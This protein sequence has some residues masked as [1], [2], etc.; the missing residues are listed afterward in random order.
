[1]SQ[2]NIYFILLLRR[3]RATLRLNKLLPP[4]NEWWPKI[5]CERT[6]KTNVIDSQ[7]YTWKRNFPQKDSKWQEQTIRMASNSVHLDTGHLGKN[8]KEESVAS[9]WGLYPGTAAGNTATYAGN[10]PRPAIRSNVS[11][12]GKCNQNNNTPLASQRLS[13]HR[14]ITTIMPIT[15]WLLYS[16]IIVSTQLTGCALLPLGKVQLWWPKCVSHCLI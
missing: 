3:S 12:N 8:C 11:T 6:W 14:A 9:G 16:I 10:R 2:T 7:N 15:K 13:P 1:M 5:K 4:V